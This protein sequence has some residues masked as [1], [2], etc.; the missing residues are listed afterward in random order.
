MAIVVRCKTDDQ[1]YVLLGS[2]FDALESAKKGL[3]SNAATKA[4]DPLA[5]VCV[6]NSEGVVGWINSSD[7][8]VI[9]VDGLSV[10]SILDDKLN[11]SLV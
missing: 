9:T 5:M 6:C 1:V 11:E 3:F 2:G 8:T 4:K 10:Q 7:V